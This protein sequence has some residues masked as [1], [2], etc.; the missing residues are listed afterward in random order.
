MKTKIYDFKNTIKNNSLNEIVGILKSGGLVAIP[1]ETVYGL[2]ANGLNKTAVSNIFKAK[3]RP[4]D[5]PLI[6][7][8]SNIDQIYDLTTDVKNED[9]RKIEKLWPG[10]LTVI[11]NKSEI[12]PDEVSAKLDTVAIRMPNNEIISKIIDRLDKPIAAPSANLSTKP[13]PT[14][15]DA[16]IEDMDGRIDAIIDGGDCNI[17]IESTVLDLSEDIPRI[18]RPGFY[19]KEILE[20]YWP[21]IEMDLSLKEKSATPKSPGQKYK[22]YAPNATIEVL[23]GD[24]EDFRKE[25]LNLLDEYSDKKIGLMVFDDDKETFNNKNIESIVYMGSKDDLSYMAKILFD[26]FRKMDDNNIEHIIVRGVEEEDFGLSIMN[27]LKK[28]SSQNIRRV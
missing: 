6:L 16:V 10:P 25:V 28:A 8:I 11:F 24:D 3:N 4:M 5:N 7:H 21:N 23:I 12:I 27:R 13:S 17:G 2:G 14:N 18:L 1:T 9:I 15:V 22:H 20:K 26:S 19:T